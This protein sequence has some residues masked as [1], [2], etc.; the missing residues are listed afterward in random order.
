MAIIAQRVPAYDLERT[1]FVGPGD[2][3][4]TFY[5]LTDETFVVV[6]GDAVMETFDIPNY[7]TGDLGQTFISCVWKVRAKGSMTISVQDNMNDGL[8]W[9]DRGT[10]AVDSVGWSDGGVDAAPSARLLATYADYLVKMRYEILTGSGEIDTFQGYLV[11][12]TEGETSAGS[13]MTPVT[14]DG[15]TSEANG[16]MVQA[17]MAGAGTTEP[18]MGRTATTDDFLV[19]L[20]LA[21]DPQWFDY[22]IFTPP[23]GYP[24]ATLGAAVVGVQ[25]RGEFGVPGTLASFAEYVIRQTIQAITA[26]LTY[27][28]NGKPVYGW[29]PIQS[30]PFVDGVDYV[31]DPDYSF[32]D[33]DVDRYVTFS[34]P[35]TFNHWSP[36]TASLSGLGES[37]PT[38]RLAVTAVAPTWV[39]IDGNHATPM[40][41]ASA[42]S[43]QEFVR[44]QPVIDVD[45][46]AM[47]AQF[48][49]EWTPSEMTEDLLIGLYCDES[50]G[51]GGGWTAT[52]YVNPSAISFVLNNPDYTYWKPGVGGKVLPLRQVQRDDGLVRSV[53]RARGTRSVQKSIRQRGYR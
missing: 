25:P 30:A 23:L 8:G 21:R 3:Y 41:W 17:Q 12:G 48:A 46:S 4:T 14:G 7:V 20:G 19:A 44:D 6:V 28:W 27:S 53:V 18:Q 5:N 47:P 26:E 9:V 45:V 35:S 38:V 31:I 50:S 22:S 1:G 29:A 43:T 16:T 39:T 15:F 37:P 24:V 40:P 36:L 11:G 13:G 32:Y 51:T 2:E 34:G 42:S 10:I 33:A 52:G 49:L